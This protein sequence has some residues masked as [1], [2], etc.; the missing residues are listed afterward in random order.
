MRPL[1]I[2]FS[3]LERTSWRYQY[4]S[5][6]CSKC[7]QSYLTIQ[8][9]LG[10]QKGDVHPICGTEK[11]LPDTWTFFFSHGVREKA[12]LSASSLACSPAEVL[13]PAFPQKIQSLEVSF[14]LGACTP[15]PPNKDLSPYMYMYAFPHS[16]KMVPK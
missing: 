7:M 3:N 11:Q 6:H 12:P 2:S 10:F 14:F 15:C 1:K 13:L 4:T 16:L 5:L 9:E 8:L